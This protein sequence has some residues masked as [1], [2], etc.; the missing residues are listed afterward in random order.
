MEANRVTAEDT[1]RGFQGP[2]RN[3][4]GS[5]S[6]ES[7]SPGAAFSSLPEQVWAARK[8]RGWS[9][10][11][12]ERTAPSSQGRG[13][14]PARGSPWEEQRTIWGVELGRRVKHRKAPLRS[15]NSI[16]CCKPGKERVA[17]SLRCVTRGSVTS[18][19]GKGQR[20]TQGSPGPASNA[21]GQAHETGNTTRSEKQRDPQRGARSHGRRQ[22]IGAHASAGQDARE[23]QGDR[24]M[25]Q[26]TALD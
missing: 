1:E 2:R 11:T 24:G 13:R 20:A 26:K 10:P 23:A 6:V 3:P 25:P 17:S 15:V 12:G 16:A 19:A 18:G 8:H 9:E 5:P 22:A 21:N 4:R 14:V 7:W